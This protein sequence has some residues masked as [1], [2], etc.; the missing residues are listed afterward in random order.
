MTDPVRNWTVSANVAF[1]TS[2]DRVL[3]YKEAVFE[4]AQAL[5][6]NGG[7]TTGS[8]QFGS[9][10]GLVLGTP[11]SWLAGTLGVTYGGETVHFLIS[12]N[13]S[14]ASTPRNALVF[15]ATEAYTGGGA[16]VLPTT[17]G[18]ETRNTCENSVIVNTPAVAHRRAIW[19]STQGDVV[20]AVK[21]EGATTPFNFVYALISIPRSIPAGQVVHPAFGAQ[22]F[23]GFTSSSMTG[24]SPAWWSID[25]SAGSADEGQALIRGAASIVQAAPAFNA[26]TGPPVTVAGET[27]GNVSPTSRMQ[28]FIVPNF[29]DGDIHIEY[30][31]FYFCTTFVPYKTKAA[32][33]TGA[34]RRINVGPGVM[35]FWPGTE[36]IL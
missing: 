9:A 16:G 7:S 36:S 20:F 8:N 6:A 31:D 26:S 11:G 18:F 32:N 15:Y 29:L 34:L 23:S 28:L 14:N 2:T 17:S 21:I 27:I 13:D 5:L 25:P 33:D 35:M 12:V 19:T 30:P 4:L 24:S 1:S 10:A 3:L 22:S